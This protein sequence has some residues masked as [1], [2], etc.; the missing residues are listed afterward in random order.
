MA[1]E[2]VVKF[3]IDGANQALAKVDAVK[4]KLTGVGGGGSP[5]QKQA[6]AEERQSRAQF[7][8][9]AKIG[10]LASGLGPIGQ[11]A[12]ISGAATPGLAAL[13]IAAVAAGASLKIASA[14]IG[15]GIQ[16]L[17][18]QIKTTFATRNTLQAATTSANQSALGFAMSNRQKMLEG[19]NAK[20]EFV[21]LYKTLDTVQAQIDSAQMDRALKFGEGEMRSELTRVKSPEAVALGD[22]SKQ[23]QENIGIQREISAKMNWLEKAYTFIS[24]GVQGKG[25]NA[26]VIGAQGQLVAI[27]AGSTG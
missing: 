13:G 22:L 26:G 19:G 4:R 14:V 2:A 8:K 20:P 16:Q 1:G 3:V 6:A 25:M 12:E 10:Q 5:G 15:N 27:S 21:A 23:A 24:N 11:L 17:E 7:G 9:F 18:S